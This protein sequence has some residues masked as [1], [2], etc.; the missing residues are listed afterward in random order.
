M[1]SRELKK[2]DGTNFLEWQAHSRN[3]HDYFVVIRNVRQVKKQ[4]S[5]QASVRAAL[6]VSVRV[7]PAFLL[8]ISEK[9]LLDVVKLFEQLEAW[10]KPFRFLDLPAELRNRVYGLVVRD[11]AGA[12]VTGVE[13]TWEIFDSACDDS[14]EF[15][16]S[17]NLPSMDK[18]SRQVRREF[19][20]VFTA[21]TRFE[22]VPPPDHLAESSDDCFGNVMRSW[23]KS[24][25]PW[26]RGLRKFH[27]HPTLSV[28]DYRRQ[29]TIQ[30][31]HLPRDDDAR[32]ELDAY[33]TTIEDDR[34]A[35][36]L[37]GESI[38]LALI[39]KPGIWK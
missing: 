39:R 19:V 6:R 7:E 10:S 4:P 2:L 28:S 12:P 16:R 32:A 36:D 1:I 14:H 20:E 38:I 21:T 26:L 33:M 24:Y 15:L 9:T 3:D 8:K 22:A 27:M 35:L 30:H 13:T 37:K 11:E 34:K 5:R 17:P 23:T 29:L 18:A 25:R 31:T